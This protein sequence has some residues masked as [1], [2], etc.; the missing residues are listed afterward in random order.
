MNGYDM[1]NPLYDATVQ[2]TEEAILN[3]MV[4]AKN[5]DRHQWKRCLCTTQRPRFK[6]SKKV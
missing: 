4:S 1:I 5:D 6:N 3:A 2:A